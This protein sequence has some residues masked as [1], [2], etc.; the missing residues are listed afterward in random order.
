MN[1]WQIFVRVLPWRP[2]PALASLWW[3]LT[4]KRVR[5][6]NRLRVAGAPLPFAYKLWMRN[7]EGLAGGRGATVSQTWNCRPSFDV[8]VRPRQSDPKAVLRTI[9]SIEGQSYPHW[10]LIVINPDIGETTADQSPCSSWEEALSNS[11]SDFI[12]PVE[13]GDQLSQCALFHLAEAL[14]SERTAAIIY[15]DED[16]IDELGRR[17]NPWFKPRWNEELFLAHDYLSRACAL[18]VPLIQAIASKQSLGPD[19]GILELLLWAIEQRD[20]PI[21]H[22]PH[23]ITHVDQ[24]RRGPT[25]VARVDAVAKYAA[26]T[27]ATASAG[28]HGTVKVSW[29]LPAELPLVSIIIP[30]KNRVELLK[31]CIDTVLSRTSYT[32]YEV[33]IVDNGSAERRTVEYLDRISAD[34][35]VRVLRYPHPYN[36]SAINNFAV[37]DAQGSYVCLL[38]NDTEVVE[39]DWLS[40]MMRYAV[41]PEIGAVGAKLLYSDGT[42]QHAGVVVGIGDAAG[43]A[44]RYLPA[45]ETGYFCQAHVPHYVSAVTGACLLLDKRKFFAAGGL[46]EDA[47]PIAFNDVDLCLKL[48]RAGWRNIYVPHAVLIHH[49]SKSRGKDHAPSQI[50]RYQ[51][52]LEIFQDRWGSKTY[53]DPLLNPNLDRF[54]ETF[55]IRF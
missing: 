53:D 29:P 45:A 5:A 6:R 4:G 13:E 18:R 28:P 32:P 17:K 51:R 8:I 47:L 3:Q 7:I 9:R 38:N 20:G 40:E 19:V 36:Y 16:Q 25:Q 46:D 48:E 41:R 34:P 52:E 12:V 21:L 55:V 11:S 2:I 10:R 24:A 49:E 37:R 15:G 27:G 43:H 33:I 22:V 44:H 26:R 39:A 31:P 14:Q 54:S 50:G 42:I 35:R 23:I 1:F 30:T